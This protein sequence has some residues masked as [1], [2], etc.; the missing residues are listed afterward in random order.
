[1]G[2]FGH[3]CGH[4]YLAFKPITV[5]TPFQR[6]A[7]DL[8]AHAKASGVLFFFWYSLTMIS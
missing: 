7:D 5:D 2:V 3:G 8:A 1:M 4:L 6:N